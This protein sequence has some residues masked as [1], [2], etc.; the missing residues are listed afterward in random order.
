MMQGES[1]RGTIRFCRERYWRQSSRVS[2]ETLEESR[3]RFWACDAIDK[4]LCDCRDSEQECMHSHR[5]SRSSSIPRTL[6]SHDKLAQLGLGLGILSRHQESKQPRNV[7]HRGL[8]SS[9]IEE[10]CWIHCSRT[11]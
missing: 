5:A 11:R 8:D 10:L 7:I 1:E 4:S 2:Q 6:Q 3:A 9:L